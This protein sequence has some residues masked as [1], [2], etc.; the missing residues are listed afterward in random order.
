MMKIMKVVTTYT[1]WFK[2]PNTENDR[3][4]VITVIII[5]KINNSDKKILII[6]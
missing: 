4:L 5:I 6:Y 2:N 3:V 1:G